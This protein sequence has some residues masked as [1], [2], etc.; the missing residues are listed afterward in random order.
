MAKGNSAEKSKETLVAEN[1]K[2]RFSYGIEDTFEAGIVL[3]GTEVKSCRAHKVT[4][5]DGYCM[6][7]GTDLY[8]HNVHINEFSHGNRFN[9]EPRAV[10]KLLL[11]KKELE[12]LLPLWQRDY[13]LIPLKMYIKGSFI[14]VLIGVGRAKKAHDKRQDLKKKDTQ[15]EIDR[16]MKR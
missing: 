4:L 9:H 5:T 15:R 16:A 3:R 14:K 8:L 10:R 2:A 6:F 1:R 11:K 12:K 13:N 7:R